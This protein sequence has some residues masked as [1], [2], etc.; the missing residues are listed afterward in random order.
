MIPC[1]TKLVFAATICASTA[2][3]EKYDTAW[4]T[5]IMGTSCESSMQLITKSGGPG[6]VITCERT[7]AGRHFKFPVG[8]FDIDQQVV[9]PSGTVI[10]GNANP[11]DPSDKTKKPEPSTQTYFV[12]TRGVSSHGIAYCGT[13]GNMGPGQAQKLR[14]GFLL[15]SNTVVKKINFQ[16][17]DTKRPYDNGS[18]C[19]GAAFETPGCVSPGFAD[20]P[21]GSWSG[22]TGCYD[23][24]GN[25]NDLVTG[26]G[27]G[28]ENV[29]IEDVRLNDLLG[30][31][32][33]TQIAVW[34]AQTKDGSATSNVRVS[35]LVSMLTR[36]D[37]INFHGNVQNSVVE[38]S[39][40][41]NTGDDIYAVWGGYANSPAG[42]V[43]RDNVGKN[44]GMTRNYG[45]GVCIA[46]YGARDVTFTGMK[47]YDPPMNH[48]CEHGPF[49]NS[50]LAYVHDG[51]F[52][53]VYPDGN[54]VKIYGNEYLTMEGSPITDRPQ[55][56]SDAGKG[57]SHINVMS[58][59]GRRM[60]ED[61]ILP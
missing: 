57:G 45:Y 48:A 32:Q 51:W 40:I 50:C 19:G 6:G 60:L 7:G 25:S 61:V 5:L 4:Q 43:F 10:E 14:I 37:G 34:V 54:T 12:A 8:E 53:A 15:N 58:S 35:N 29:I 3:A 11:N 16:G 49:C 13:G 23:R 33:G 2:A 26:D 27:R 1:F 20:G 22:R 28:V 30:G 24:T 42:I 56:R 21:G 59:G 47:C 17:K 36:G 55:V 9:V 46:V 41:Q 44:A 18:L 31:G 39:Y 52:G 38:N